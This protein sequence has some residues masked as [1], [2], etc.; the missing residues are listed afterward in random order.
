[1]NKP[2]HNPGVRDLVEAK[3]QWHYRQTAEDG[4][5]GFRGWHERGRLPHFDAPG[6]TQFVTFRLADSF[7]QSRRSEWE[8]LFKIEDDRERAK[9]LEAYL[10]RGHGECHLRRADAARVVEGALL[11]FHGQNYEV[12]AWVVMPNH[13]HVL[14]QVGEVSMENIVESWKSWTSNEVNKLLGRRG[15]LW[16]PGYWDTYMRDGEHEAKTVR[17]VENNPTKAKLVLDPK[18][19]P[20]S[21]ARYRDRYAR[22]VVPERRASIL[23]AAGMKGKGGA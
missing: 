18:E 15:R 6:V 13:V 1:M 16:Q 11:F 20:W 12:R 22:L 2:P 17:Y 9:E 23:A 10:D 3:R 8:V 4:R 19:W 14:F 7:P 21:S 5:R